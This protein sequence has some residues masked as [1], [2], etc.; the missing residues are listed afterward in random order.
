[1]RSCLLDLFFL[2][3]IWIYI[4][5]RSVYFLER[6]TWL[7][8]YCKYIKYTIFVFN[9]PSSAWHLSTKP[10]SQLNVTLFSSMMPELISCHRLNLF[11]LPE[12]WVCSNIA[13]WGYTM[14]KQHLITHP[15]VVETFDL[16]LARLNICLPLYISCRWW[17]VTNSGVWN[18][19]WGW[20]GRK[21]EKNISHHVQIF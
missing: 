7:Y 18:Y 8:V 20:K 17:M 14:A 3:I 6:I 15:V 16:V 9:M 13:F 10:D 2:S 4:Y 12:W 5:L 21:K 11:L 19:E 1:M